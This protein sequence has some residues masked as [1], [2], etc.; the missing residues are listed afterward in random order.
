MRLILRIH[1]FRGYSLGKT[2]FIEAV[3]EKAMKDS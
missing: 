1:I 2:E 3:L